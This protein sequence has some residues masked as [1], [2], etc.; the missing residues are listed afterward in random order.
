MESRQREIRF[1]CRENGKVP[2][3]V[4]V[5]S[6]K[7]IRG[8]AII[9]TKIDRVEAGNLGVFNYVGDGICELKINF[10]PGYRIYFG[11]EGMNVVILLCG[12]DKSTQQRDVWTAKEYW[13]DYNRRKIYE[14]R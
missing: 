10:G 13:A 3:R 2:F 4:W 8:R 9:E 11:Q 6:L 12:G 1:Y 7:D 5:E 14:K